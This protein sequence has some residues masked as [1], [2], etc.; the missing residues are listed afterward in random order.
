MN[1]FERLKIAF[2]FKQKF[3]LEKMTQAIKEHFSA[4]RVEFNGVVE[5]EDF[6]SAAR[7]AWAVRDAS[8]I[9]CIN[10][11]AEAIK[12]EKTL[13]IFSSIQTALENGLWWYFYDEK[14]QFH[15]MR[16]PQMKMKDGKLHCED[17]PAFQNVK[18]DLYFLNGI[19]VP[20]DLVMTPS[21]KLSMDIFHKE[22]NA[23]VRAE[24]I[25]K[26][27]IERMCHLGRMI[28]TW[29]NYPEQDWFLKSRY[30]L[31][32]MAPIFQNV[33][34]APHLKMVNQTTGIY[35]LEAVTPDCKTIKDALNLRTQENM[36]E[37]EISWIA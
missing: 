30:E 15:F 19:L 4:L 22:K 13:S 6:A 12:E 17:G 1:H 10:P 27:G 36:D 20:K 7:A 35:H 8:W 5:H 26:Y 33:R 37:H 23:D 3:D 28:D 9:S 24:F 32:D 14:N 2:D 18:E 16:I 31:V 25:R 11:G 34:Y 21:E 29:E